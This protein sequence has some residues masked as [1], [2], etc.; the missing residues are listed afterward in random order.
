MSISCQPNKP[1][2]SYQARVIQDTNRN[3]GL[4]PVFNVNTGVSPCIENF[5]SPTYPCNGNMCEP[6]TGLTIGCPNGYVLTSGNTLCISGVTTATTIT[7]DPPCLHNLSEIDTF[8]I[9]FDLSSGSTMYTGYTGEFCYSF[10]NSLP[11]ASIPNTCV[12]YSDITGNTL[13][14]TFTLDDNISAVD[15]TYRV[16]SWNKFI[17]KCMTNDLGKT[18]TTIDTSNYIDLDNDCYFVTTVNPPKPT[19]EFQPVDILS[20]ITF[21]N[22]TLNVIPD[23]DQVLLSANPVGSQ[24]ILTVNGL[25]LSTTDYTLD[26]I[27]NK[28][29]TINV[30]LEATDVVSAAYNKN[31]GGG[32]NGISDA[33]K[34]EIFSVTGVTTGVTSSFSATTYENIVN[35]NDVNNRTEI[36]LKEK[37]DPSVQPRLTING[38]NLTYDVDFFKSNFVQNKLI[39]NEGAVI[40]VGDIISVYY[41]YTGVN[42]PGDLGTLRTDSP[43]IKWNAQNNVMKNILS[44]GQFD[45]EIADRDDPNFTNIVKTSSILYNNTTASYTLNVGQITTTSIDNYIYRI[46]FTKNYGTSDPSNVYT[47]IT[48]SDIGSFKLDWSYIGNTNF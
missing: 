5:V 11:A 30:A 31:S 14:K 15:N 43:T 16:R 2:K 27:D 23:T 33:V 29:I 41:Y 13:T 6:I 26:L 46:K 18:G 39:L 1:Q 32:T 25:A 38:V 37:I 21:V 40:D 44:Y 24:V 47:T 10:I 3:L 12:S 17:S 36:Y 34:L 9:T 7:V 19:L 45:V 35:Y 48:Y 28:L 22:E 4:S 8:D 42:N 20:E